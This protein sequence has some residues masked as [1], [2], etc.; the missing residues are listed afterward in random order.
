MAKI[1]AAQWYKN[2]ENQQTA[3]IENQRRIDDGGISIK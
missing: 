3:S 2:S 1:V